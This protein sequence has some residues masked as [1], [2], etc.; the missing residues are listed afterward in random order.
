V[1][2]EEM[3]RRGAADAESERLNAFYYQHYYPYRRGYDEMRRRLG[4]PGVRF[5]AGRPL[6]IW[7]VVALLIGAAAAWYASQGQPAAPP[8]PGA[9]TLAQA[10]TRTARPTRTPIFPTATPSPT[11]TATPVPQLRVG[12]A[13]TVTTTGLRARS[14]PSL[15]ARVEATFRSG[16]RVTIVEGPREA[17]GYTWWRIEGSAGSGWSAERSPDGAVWLTPVP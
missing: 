13:A 2:T 3:Y 8:A 10:P 16:E 11:P 14:E 5:R 9:A 4:R 7:L 17:D 1:D 15:K 12:V 6:L